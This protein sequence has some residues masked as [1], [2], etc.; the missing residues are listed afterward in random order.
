MTDQHV[1]VPENAALAAY[2]TADPS[3]Y[4]GKLPLTDLNQWVDGCADASL[5]PDEMLQ[6]G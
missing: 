3:Q 2:S 4:P 5:T 1:A 6:R